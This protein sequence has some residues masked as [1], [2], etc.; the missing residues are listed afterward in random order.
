MVDF[1][2]DWCF[3]WQVSQ[4]LRAISSYQ[5]L[6]FLIQLASLEFLEEIV[7]DLPPLPA[8]FQPPCKMKYVVIFCV[9]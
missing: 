8:A 1:D 2:I 4:Y 6:T 9:I 3:K 5:K 7:K